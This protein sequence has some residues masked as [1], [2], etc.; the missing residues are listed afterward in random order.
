[1][2]EKHFLLQDLD[3]YSPWVGIKKKIKYTASAPTFLCLV[4]QSVQ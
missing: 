4:A 3:T 2:A 1:M